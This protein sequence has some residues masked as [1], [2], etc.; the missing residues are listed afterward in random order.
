MTAT[1][2]T[3]TKARPRLTPLSDS[4][5]VKLAAVLA[6]YQF[7]LTTLVTDITLRTSVQR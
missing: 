7:V 2:L 6:F 3:R 1:E 5:S 4:I